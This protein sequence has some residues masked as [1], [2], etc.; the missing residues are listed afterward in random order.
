[1]RCSVGHR[2]C[3][4]EKRLFSSIAGGSWK[5]RYSTC[6]GDSDVLKASWGGTIPKQA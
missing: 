5:E 1:M 2:V 6:A 4:C 3:L